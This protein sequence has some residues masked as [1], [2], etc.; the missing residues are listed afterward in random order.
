MPEPLAPQLPPAERD[1]QRAALRALVELS[2]RCAGREIQ[3]EQQ[4]AAALDSDNKELDKTNWGVEERFKNQQ[5]AIK[6]KHEGRISAAEGKYKIDFDAL[7]HGDNLARQRLDHEKNAIDRE[8]KKSFEQAAWLAESVF[9][10]GQIGINE[11]FKKVNDRIA[12]GIKSLEGMEHTA[13]GVMQLYRQQPPPDEDL[14]T[15]E[16]LPAVVG[17]AEPVTSAAALPV[18]DAA[19]VPAAP[20][21]IQTPVAP[22]AT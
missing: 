12:E 11:G 14:R 1:L 7:K 8:V 15:A 13:A 2:E 19:I 18:A 20:T 9:D 5:D 4:H 3:I 21:E 22:A 16:V 6:Q 17:S 10:A